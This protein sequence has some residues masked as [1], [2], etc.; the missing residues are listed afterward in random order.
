MRILSF[1]SR[2]Q[3]DIRLSAR[4]QTVQKSNIVHI[5]K[6]QTTWNRFFKFQ[7]KTWYN[8]LKWI[9]FSKFQFENFQVLFNRELFQSYDI[10]LTERALVHSTI[11]F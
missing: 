3:N 4:T 5:F 7:R 11:F 10:Y 2:K 6:K 1:T 8:F 9:K